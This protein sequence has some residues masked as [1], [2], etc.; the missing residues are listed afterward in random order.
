MAA[1]SPTVP[2][3][4]ASRPEMVLAAG[5][6]MRG[7]PG[8]GLPTTGPPTRWRRV[9]LIA[10]P[11][12]SSSMEPDNFHQ[13][14]GKQHS[15]GFQPLI[16]TAASVSHDNSD[17]LNRLCATS[18]GT[19]SS[20]SSVTASVHSRAARSRSLCPG[21]SRRPF[22]CRVSARRPRLPQI[23]PVHV[24]A[25]R[26][27]RPGR[28]TTRRMCGGSSQGRLHVLGDFNAE[29]VQRGL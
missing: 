2:G 12:S 1:S 6:A 24:D 19:R 23:V 22:T 26:A 28:T 7:G 9:L 10:R 16:V 18:S 5:R 13:I 15:I 3:A 14:R 4:G 27:N 29:H 21:H 17:S 20:V 25:V 11:P 8:S